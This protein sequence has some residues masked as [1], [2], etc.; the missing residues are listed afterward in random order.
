MA[1]IYAAWVG[2]KRLGYIIAAVS[3]LSIAS[4]NIVRRHESPESGI[5]L[6]GVISRVAVISTVV[7]LTAYIAKLQRETMDRARRDPLTGLSN[8]IVLMERLALECDRRR[9]S[10]NSFVFAYMDLDGFK[11]VNDTLGHDEEDQVRISV[12]ET[13][14]ANIRPSDLAARLG[15]DEFCLLLS[16]TAAAGL[17]S[18]ERMQAGVCQAMEAHGWAVT[19]SIGMVDA[20]TT[21]AITPKEI[22]ARQRPGGGRQTGGEDRVVSTTPRATS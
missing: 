13:L 3:M 20:G 2:G 5:F 16:D 6:T 8:R 9:R 15:G 21:G 17:V 14:R 12:A 22:I 10:K 1:A 18:L 11:A 4:Y 19:M 7:Y